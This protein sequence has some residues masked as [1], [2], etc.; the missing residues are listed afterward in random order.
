M[1]K[2]HFFRIL[3]PAVLIAF[4]GLLI[5]AIR[6]PDPFRPPQVGKKVSSAQ[7]VTFTEIVRDETKFTARAEKVTEDES[8]SVRMERITD[9][10]YHRPEKA[11]L[12][13]NAT[14]GH[15]DGE[16]GQRTILFDEG[17]RVTDPEDELTLVIPSLAIDQAAG[18]ARASGD[19]R[20]EGALD[21]G[22][23]R[24]IYALEDR[25]TELHDLDVRTPEGGRVVARRALLHDGL[26]DV[27]LIQDV[28]LQ[29]GDESLNARRIRVRRR[30]NKTLDNA[31]A[32][33]GV[34]GEWR[35][36]GG[37][38]ELACDN[39]TVRWNAQGET[40]RADLNG[41][42]R[43]QRGEDRLEA[44]HL[45]LWRRAPED[46]PGWGFSATGNVTMEGIFG[47]QPGQLRARAVEAWTGAQ[48]GVERARAVGRATFEAQDTRG[49]ANTAEYLL[50]SG[51]EIR[52]LGTQRVKA[53]LAR[54]ATRVAA[55]EI[56]TDTLGQ[57][58]IADQRVEATLLPNDGRGVEYLQ[59]GLFRTDDAVHFVAAR[60]EG[61]NGGGYLEFTSNVR[62]W[63]ADRT[64]SADRVI[65]DRSEQ[66]LTAR[67][68]VSLQLPRSSSFAGVSEADYLQ[69]TAGELDYHDGDGLAVFRDEVRV[70]L[71]E[72][73]VEASRLEIDLTADRDIHEVR[74]YKDVSLEFR[75]A[76]DDD[77][78]PQLLSGLADRL[79]YSPAEATIWLYGDEAPASVRQL[80]PGG[81]TTT[82]RVLR[83]SLI[84]GSL[85]VESGRTSTG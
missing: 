72:G 59:A 1:R 48:L 42:V 5:W 73:W 82:G 66:T 55:D 13:I 38:V 3:L 36:S 12:Q 17:V 74:A 77:E 84:D 33:G 41:N 65:L 30:P 27:E 78:N 7:G 25:P 11:P 40:M 26:D 67:D 56:V 80:G 20:L 53:R 45:R 14:S 35:P 64:L 58:L 46:S 76:G 37:L 21:G 81:A 51:N 8:G 85:A 19:V 24:A 2:V 31:H 60:L 69:I 43:L 68:D 71:A 29:Q 61:R 50:A 6:T 75:Q 9:F 10:E 49:E 15:I 47:G 22:A 16:P 28:R 34:T 39:A 63:Q 23:S 83:Y 52:L 70:R 54:G 44:K 57:K 79:I 62:G 32:R 4:V 18:E